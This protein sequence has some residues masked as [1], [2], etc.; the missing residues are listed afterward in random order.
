[1]T[2]AMIYA[3]VIISHDEQKHVAAGNFATTSIMNMLTQ[4]VKISPNSLITG[5]KP[6][7]LTKPRNARRI[8]CK[9]EH[10][11]LINTRGT[12]ISCSL[13]STPSTRMSSAKHS[14]PRLAGT[15]DVGNLSDACE[16]SQTESHPSPAHDRG[17]VGSCDMARHRGRHSSCSGVAQVRSRVL[18]ATTG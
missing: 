3:A 13:A 14:W 4:V 1:S 10:V 11:E 8:S 9:S 15:I 2:L 17:R 6:T 7:E 5:S 18:R 16:R 12:A